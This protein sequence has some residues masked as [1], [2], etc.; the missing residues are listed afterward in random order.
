MIVCICSHNKISREL[1][2]R[3]VLERKVRL[4]VLEG[5]QGAAITKGT[6]ALM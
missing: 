1:P 6:Q 4:A 5:Q 3:G 2:W